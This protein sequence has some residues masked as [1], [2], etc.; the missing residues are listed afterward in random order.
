MEK[1]ANI[2]YLP[3]I[4]HFL[5]FVS[6]NLLLH[7][8]EKIEGRSINSCTKS[9][10]EFYRLSSEEQRQ[11]QRRRMAEIVDFAAHNVPYYT[12]VFKQNKISAEKIEKD[13]RYALDIPFLTKDI[14]REEGSRLLSKS[15]DDVKYHACKTGGSTGPSCIIYYDQVAA[16]Y[17]AA[18]TR[19]ARQNIGK[20]WHRSELHFAAD[21]D[22]AQQYSY[23]QRETLKSI[24]M[25]RSNVFLSDI[26]EISL[27][28]VIKKLNQR[29]PYIVHGHPST[30]Y[31]LALFAEKNQ[32]TIKKI[33]VIEPSGEFCSPK[34][35][36][37]IQRAFKGLIHNRYGLAEFG[38]VG[39]QFDYS[40]EDLKIFNSE[41]Y[42]E[43]LTHNSSLNE[44]VFTGFRN[45]LMPLIRYRTGDMADQIVENEGAFLR[46]LKG[47]IH[48]SVKI[49]SNEYLTHYIQDILDHRVGG[50]VEFQIVNE[51]GRVT[52]LVQSEDIKNQNYIDQKIRKY[53]P[54]LWDVKFVSANGLIKSGSR[55][56]FRHLVNL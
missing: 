5:G 9:I 46:G 31:Q 4:R 43:L 17:S 35:A 8:A 20:K 56:K 42:A 52:F 16:D 37:T 18:V 50:I 44:I 6:N 53:F 21:F 36:A 29:R 12:D 13:I 19:Y 27:T 54:E 11:E 48:D 38:I 28:A 3:A 49:G 45:K 33:P 22:E 23:F 14:I 2:A 26:N 10:R 40:Q 51:K 47:R 1:I 32:K 15:L 39:Y 41:V 25:N 30:L 34:M 55:N 7:I 24:A